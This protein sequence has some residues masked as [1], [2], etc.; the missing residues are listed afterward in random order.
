MSEKNDVDRRD[1]RSAIRHGITAL[2]GIVA[3]DVWQ[4]VQQDGLSMNIVYRAA[5]VS[6]LAAGVRLIQRWQSDI[7]EPANE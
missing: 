5:A 6:V 4:A 2:A 1:V 3:V 7:R